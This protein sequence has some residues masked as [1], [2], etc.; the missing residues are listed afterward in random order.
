MEDDE[1]VGGWMDEWDKQKKFKKRK[2][3]KKE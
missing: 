3:K 2:T 1:V